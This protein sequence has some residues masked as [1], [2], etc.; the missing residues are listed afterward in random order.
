MKSHKSDDNGS[1]NWRIRLLRGFRLESVGRLWFA[2]WR[3]SSTHALLM[4]KQIS[5]MPAIPL[6]CPL[7]RTKNYV[8]WVRNASA[9]NAQDVLC[10]QQLCC[11][12]LSCVSL[13]TRIIP[14]RR[15]T[16][17]CI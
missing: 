9:R 8:A 4:E 15:K 5:R 7:R 10:N 2:D 11:M 14:E 3:R 13:S 16:I 1:F 12:K 17:L 6:N